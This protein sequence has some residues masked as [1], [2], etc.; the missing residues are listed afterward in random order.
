MLGVKTGRF[1][2]AARC[3]L[4]VRLEMAVVLGT[5]NGQLESC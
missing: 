4:A 5:K 3:T 1:S 2:V